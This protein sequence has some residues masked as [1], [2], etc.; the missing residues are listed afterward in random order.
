MTATLDSVANILKEYYD[1]TDVESMLLE[2]S[3]TL[4]II[5]KRTD[6]GGS[7]MP[8][9]FMYAPTAGVSPSF[10]DAQAAKA[11]VSEE[12]WDIVTHDLYSLFSL[13]HKAVTMAKGNAKSFV[14]LVES[15]AD[16]AI[17]AAKKMYNRYIFGNGSGALGQILSNVGATLTLTERSAMH[18]F[19]RNLQ[20]TSSTTSTTSSVDLAVLNRIATVNRQARTLT[21]VAG[22]W[23]AVA[24]A[25]NNYVM[26]RGGVAN[27]IRGFD[28]WLPGTAPSATPFFGVDRTVDS[29]TYGVIRDANLGVDANLEECL[30]AA[31]ADIADQGGAPKYCVMN[32]RARKQLIAQ[33]GAKVTYER[34][35]A[36]KSD[37]DNHATIGFRAVMIEGDAG[38]I[39]VIGDRNCPYGRYYMLDTKGMALISAGPLIDFLKYED[40]SDKFVRHGAENAMEARMGGYAQMTFRTPGFSGTGNITALLAAEV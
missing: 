27:V 31:S 26:L 35:P 30:L 25:A 6:F 36:V 38:P 4:A 9:P 29:R 3:P 20:V 19:D 32:T 2:D 17:V 15:R 34:V 5:P 39:K 28:A 16:A 22:S 23:D 37:G 8:L 11:D 14:D 40:D 33:L 1:D 10:P 24:Y 12:K 7:V 21:N 18:V 13:D